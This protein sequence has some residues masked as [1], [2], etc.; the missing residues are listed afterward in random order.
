MISLFLMS[1]LSFSHVQASKMVL[2][3]HEREDYFARHFIEL[4]HHLLNRKQRVL[5][6]LIQEQEQDLPGCHAIRKGLGGTDSLIKCMRFF[7]RESE[8]S[9]HSPGQKELKDDLILLCTKLSKNKTSTEKFIQSRILKQLDH[10]W[11]SCVGSLWQQ[12]Y[13]TAY[14]KFESDPVYTVSLVRRAEGGLPAD[15]YWALKIQ[16]LLHTP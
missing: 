14:A 1:F 10:S 16:R 4:N 5:A 11:N 15:N 12:I 13:L 6:S 7:K 3:A 9:L 8:I 2:T